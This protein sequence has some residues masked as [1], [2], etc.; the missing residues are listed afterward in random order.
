MKPSMLKG[1]GIVHKR[2][3][4]FSG[5]IFFPTFKHLPGEYA[6]FTISQTV[7]EL[8]KI[9]LRYSAVIIIGQVCFV[10]N[11]K[12]NFKGDCLT[13]SFVYFSVRWHLWSKNWP[14]Q[15]FSNFVIREGVIQPCI[16]DAD[17]RPQPVEHISQLQEE[18]PKQ[19]L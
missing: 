18:L 6:R 3:I 10:R 4:E 16:I 5:E 8:W 17:G 2:S 14:I 1:W 19:Q 7:T 12:S 15:I 11:N 13:L 9:L